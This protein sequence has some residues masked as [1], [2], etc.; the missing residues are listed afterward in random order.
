V[1][2]FVAAPL[3]ARTGGIFMAQSPNHQHARCAASME[4]N[5]MT[6]ARAL[7]VTLMGLALPTPSAQS[8][9]AA[10]QPP[11]A[12]HTIKDGRLYWVEGGGGNST[13]IIGDKGVIVIDAKTTPEAGAALVAEV[14]TLTPKPI[15]TVIET[16]SDGDHVNGIVSFPKDIRV[17]AHVNNR[18]E[19]LAVYIYAAAEVGGGKCL[20]PRDRLPNSVVVKDRVAATI[21]GV[22]MVFH[23]FGPAH[24]NGD[25]I[26][27]LPDD[28]LAVVGDL[29]TNVVLTHPEKN[30]TFAGWL[31]NA[32]G[33]LALNVNHYLGGHA[34]DLDTKDS[35]RKRMAD[36]QATG[37]QVDSMS[38]AGKSLADIKTALNVKDTMGACRGLP[39]WS[40]PEQEYYEQTNRLRELK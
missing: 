1:T 40:L 19:Q 24:T 7:S 39:Y 31:I 20:P 34:T 9:P 25:L 16:H 18:M 8:Q 4:N 22:R 23:H 10:L 33:L 29:I 38:A 3:S 27:E 13:V 32:K 14:A 21:D 2:L 37:Q 5:R 26:V 36:Y 15:D 17:I 6:I 28:R 35:L 11:L 12:V 30:G